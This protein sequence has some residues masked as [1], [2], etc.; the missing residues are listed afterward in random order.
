MAVNEKVRV[1]CM[2]ADGTTRGLLLDHS[3]CEVVN[4]FLPRLPRADHVTSINRGRLPT[5]GP[6]GIVNGGR[7]R[8]RWR[9]RESSLFYAMY[10]IYSTAV[11]MMQI[12]DVFTLYSPIMA[13]ASIPL[14]RKIPGVGGWRWALPPTPEFCV[15]DIPTCWYL[16]ANAKL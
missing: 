4:A 5:S 8:R 12:T 16:G 2:P 7:R 3:V 1:C 13:K 6:T 15:G 9:V 11:I 10:G 14:R